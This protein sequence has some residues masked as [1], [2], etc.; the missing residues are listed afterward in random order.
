M[1]FRVKNLND[2]KNIKEIT[3]KKEDSIIFKNGPIIQEKNVSSFSSNK[4]KLEK[5]AKFLRKVSLSNAGITAIES[6]SKLQFKLEGIP[7]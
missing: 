2:K 6:N 4:R 3:L 7:K 1:I 5:T